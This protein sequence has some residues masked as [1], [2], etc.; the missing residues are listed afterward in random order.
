MCNIDGSCASLPNEYIKIMQ[1]TGLKDRN[2]REIY[3]GD[4]VRLDDKYNGLIAWDLGRWQSVM[5]LHDLDIERYFD[6]YITHS[7][8]E[9]I[10]NIYE[11][12]ELL[13]D[14]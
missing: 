7:N 5:Y 6:L 10:G 4:V 12:P 14:E 3:E 1:Y 13:K 9:I 11:N 2:E 8:L